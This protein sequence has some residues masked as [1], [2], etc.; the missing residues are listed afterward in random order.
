MLPAVLL[1]VLLV[2]WLAV[3]VAVLGADFFFFFAEVTVAVVAP[4]RNAAANSTERI[5]I[6]FCNRSSSRPGRDYLSA[7]SIPSRGVAGSLL[8]GRHRAGGG[9]SY[10]TPDRGLPDYRVVREAS[11]IS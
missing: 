11:P 7:Q 5:E 2:V 6:V 9:K 8:F 3:L 10:S 1:A 4:R